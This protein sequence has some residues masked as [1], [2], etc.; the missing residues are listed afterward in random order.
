MIE[1]AVQNPNT[2]AS[3]I[4]V[5]DDWYKFYRKVKKHKNIKTVPELPYTGEHK[6]DQPV[7]WGSGCYAVLLAATLGF[8]EIKIVGFDLYPVN[9]KVNNIYKDTPNYSSSKS[10]PVDYSYWVYQINQVIKHFPDSKFIFVNRDDWEVP[11]E[12][13]K[14]N[15]EFLTYK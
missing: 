1:E 3:L 15:V 11:P 13:K 5:R 7:N 14:F 2:V 12:W 6:V 10:K 4:Y 8:K 9:E